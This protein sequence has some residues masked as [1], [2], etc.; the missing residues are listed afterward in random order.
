MSRF[1]VLLCPQIGSEG[2]LLFSRCVHKC[3]AQDLPWSRCP[4]N[5]CWNFH[6]CLEEQSLCVHVQRKAL[7]GE[8][9][10][11]QHHLNVAN[12]C[13]VVSIAIS[14]LAFQDYYESC[15]MD[16]CIERLW[17]LIYVDRHL[18]KDTWELGNS[19]YCWGNKLGNGKD[20]KRTT[21]YCI[22]VLYFGIFLW[23]W[24]P[25]K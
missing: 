8:W 9:C 5:K 6:L 18:W 16:Q 15:P 19:S 2:L 17:P 4:I 21:C 7:F 20:W 1:P 14:R 3:Q 10:Q 23:L 13:D 25:Y 24:Y 11:L 22:A 12:S